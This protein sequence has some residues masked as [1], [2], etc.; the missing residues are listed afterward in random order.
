MCN[1]NE[2]LMVKTSHQRSRLS[3]FP[4]LGNSWSWMEYGDRECCSQQEFIYLLTLSPPTVFTI[5]KHTHK[6]LSLLIM[7]KYFSYPLHSSVINK[8]WHW[9]LTVWHTL[10]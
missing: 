4:Q 5:S 6:L 2:L 7:L 8:T 1:F 10:L 9:K 3:T